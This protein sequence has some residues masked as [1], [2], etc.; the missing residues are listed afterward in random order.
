M[1][2]LLHSKLRSRICQHLRIQRGVLG[3]ITTKLVGVCCWMQRRALWHEKRTK[4]P[5]RFPFKVLL[6][7]WASVLWHSVHT[8]SFISA[9]ACMSAG[10]EG[11]LDAT[12]LQGIFVFSYVYG[13]LVKCSYAVANPISSSW[14]L[15]LIFPL[16]WLFLLHMCT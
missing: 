6:E 3:P 2:V 7:I 11:V 13:N 10:A 9:D 8:V 16:N 12:L 14:F 5:K 4:T 1:A 15:P